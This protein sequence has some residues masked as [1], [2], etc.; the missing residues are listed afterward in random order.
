VEE[1][2]NDLDVAH[3]NNDLFFG[4][5]ILENHSEVSSSSDVISTVV[6]TVAPYSEHVT[7]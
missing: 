4:I 2:N 5:P 1:A 6:H 3:M 7:K